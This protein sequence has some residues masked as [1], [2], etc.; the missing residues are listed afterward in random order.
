MRTTKMHQKAACL[1][2]SL[3]KE[4]PRI[5]TLRSTRLVLSNS[6]RG[7]NRCPSSLVKVEKPRRK[8]AAFICNS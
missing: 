1:M 5:H 2:Y 6:Q 3:A 4:T 8:T 7:C